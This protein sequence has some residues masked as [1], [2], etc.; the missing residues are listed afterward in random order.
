M[1]RVVKNGGGRVGRRVGRGGAGA[2]VVVPPLALSVS[3]FHQALCLHL[4]AKRIESV[5]PYYTTKALVVTSDGLRGLPAPAR[6]LRGTVRRG[7]K[8]LP[9][10]GQQ[11]NASHR[12]LSEN[13][14]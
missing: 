12:A 10:Q 5:Q 11:G 7:P 14:K 3:V 8:E 6:P 2:V 1:V 4:D 13:K 9:P